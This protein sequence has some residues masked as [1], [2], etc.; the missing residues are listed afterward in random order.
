MNRAHATPAVLLLILLITV[1][2]VVGGEAGTDASVAV[3]FTRHAEKG[4]DDPRDPELNDEGRRRAAA[5][6]RMLSRAG[7]SHLFSSQFKRTRQTLEPL[8]ERAAVEIDVIRAQ[9]AESQLRALRGLDA[10]AVAV[11]AGH[12]NTIPGLVCELGGRTTDLDCSSSGRQLAEDDYDRLYLVVL[13]APG[14]DDRT[15][16]QTLSLRYGP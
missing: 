16:L 4:S 14:A 2:L 9:D 11:V 5:L 1:P 10:G 13:P 12:S 7:V 3:F 6:A 15:P 8:A